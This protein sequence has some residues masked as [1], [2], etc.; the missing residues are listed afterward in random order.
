[1][2]SGNS[3]A[4]CSEILNL[5]HKRIDLW[6]CDRA[7]VNVFVHD[8]GRL[9]SQREWGAACCINLSCKSHCTAESWWVGRSLWY[10][11]PWIAR[12]NGPPGG[13]FGKGC[14]VSKDVKENTRFRILERLESCGSLMK[15]L[16]SWGSGG[17]AMILRLPFGP[18]QNPGRSPVKRGSWQL[19]QRWIWLPFVAPQLSDGVAIG[20]IVHIWDNIMSSERDVCLRKWYPPFFQWSALESDWPI[21]GCKSLA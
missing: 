2:C 11:L 15:T 8:G 1:M 16:Y 21:T 4:N 19:G 9:G 5:R 6:S 7:L 3:C 20:P 13:A 18:Q 14:V 12:K 17:S 10:T